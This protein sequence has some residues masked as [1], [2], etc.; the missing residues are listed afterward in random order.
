MVLLLSLQK[1]CFNLRYFL[2]IH[3]KFEMV[4][5]LGKKEFSFKFQ[6]KFYFLKKPL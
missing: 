6:I 3:Y 4:L 5:T 1:N 2:H